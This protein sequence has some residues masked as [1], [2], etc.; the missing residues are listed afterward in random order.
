MTTRRKLHA[1]V[2]CRPVESSPARAAAT[3]SRVQKPCSGALR[4]DRARWLCPAVPLLRSAR[5]DDTSIRAEGA[6]PQGAQHHTDLHSERCPSDARYQTRREPTSTP[7]AFP[8]DPITAHESARP[9]AGKL[10]APVRCRHRRAFGARPS[11]HL[12]G[13]EAMQR[14]SPRQPHT[15][16]AR[17]LCPA[18][19]LGCLRANSA[20]QGPSTLR[21]LEAPIVSITGILALRIT[22]VRTSRSGSGLYGHRRWTPATGIRAGA[23]ALSFGPPRRRLAR[24]TRQTAGS[25]PRESR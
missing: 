11:Q 22:A 7:D 4:A 19:P 13:A 15:I 8:A 16:R 3:A 21:Y 2:R 1:P 6:Q 9:R 20:A 18:V 14:R 5:A 17:W 25:A 12:T 24:G 10:H 23:L